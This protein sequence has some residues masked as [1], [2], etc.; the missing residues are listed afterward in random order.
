MGHDSY[1]HVKVWVSN[2]KGCL[3]SC[4]VSALLGDS[5][6]G[7]MGLDPTSAAPWCWKPSFCILGVGKHGELIGFGVLV[8]QG[9]LLGLC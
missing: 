3:S 1:P 9:W 2:E 6:A 5:L 4:H 8:G 7:F